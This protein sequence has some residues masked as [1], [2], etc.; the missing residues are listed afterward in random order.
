MKL[1][2][3]CFELFI[4]YFVN[5]LVDASHSCCAILSHWK[6]IQLWCLICV[7]ESYRQN[8]YHKMQRTLVFVY[9]FY[10]L[11][12]HLVPIPGKALCRCSY[13]WCYYSECM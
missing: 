10:T 1:I 2:H 3:T 9:G 7:I 12:R 4:T 13:A 11:N 6:H 5:I 8:F